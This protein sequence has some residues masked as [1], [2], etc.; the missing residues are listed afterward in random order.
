MQCWTVESRA[1]QGSD[2]KL[3]L[4]HL[5]LGLRGQFFAMDLMFENN[6]KKSLKG[7]CGVQIYTEGKY[8]DDKYFN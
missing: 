1:L 8:V 4:P 7:L 5:N 3:V 2:A 6:M